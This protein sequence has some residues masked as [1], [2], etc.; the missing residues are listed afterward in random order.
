M[1]KNIITVIAFVAGMSLGVLISNKQTKEQLNTLSDSIDYIDDMRMWMIE[2]MSNGVIPPDY[3]E[4]YIT[5]CEII[6]SNLEYLDSL[7]KSK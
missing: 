5:G 4:Y 2:D 3:A 6:N 7:N 1:K